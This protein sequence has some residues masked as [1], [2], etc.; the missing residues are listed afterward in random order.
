MSHP[1]LRAPQYSRAVHLLFS[2][3]IVK[4]THGW[5]YK[6]QC[7]LHLEALTSTVYHLWG[8]YANPPPSHGLSF[9]QS[10]GKKELGWVTAP[11]CL[12]ISR[13]REP[14]NIWV[15]ISFQGHPKYPNEARP[16]PVPA[17]RDPTV[18]RTARL[19]RQKGLRSQDHSRWAAFSTSPRSAFRS[20]PARRSK[21]ANTA[22]LKSQDHRRARVRS[23]WA[24][25][26]RHAGNCSLPKQSAP[27]FSSLFSWR[28]AG[29]WFA[30][31][32]QQKLAYLN[33]WPH[34]TPSLCSSK[35][36]W[37]VSLRGVQISHHYSY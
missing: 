22:M 11:Q 4:G 3:T 29:A 1:L 35:W 32:Y 23:R 13:V 15:G 5:H 7:R 25:P 37:L 36:E 17:A 34:F 19:D 20:E 8:P 6:H 21:S 27:P 16:C 24:R 31:K 33:Q 28:F 14:S 30:L 10:A 12:R 26:L 18:W 9:L 2:D